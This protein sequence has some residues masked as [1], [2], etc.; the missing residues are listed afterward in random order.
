MEAGKVYHVFNRGIN[1]QPIF[2]DDENYIFFLKQFDK[3]LS[4]KVDVLAYC[5]M[6]NHFHLFIRIK[7]IN[8]LSEMEISNAV[9]KSFRDFLISYAKAVNKKYER[10]GALFQ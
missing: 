3:Y 5:L 10:T 1:N 6:Q 2:F 8:G 7:K 4:T 9:I